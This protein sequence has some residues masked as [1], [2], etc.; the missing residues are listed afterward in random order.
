[1]TC[2]ERPYVPYII[3]CKAEDAWGSRTNEAPPQRSANSLTFMAHC[4]CP[5]AHHSSPAIQE[6]HKKTHSK[7]TQFSKVACMWRSQPACTFMVMGKSTEHKYILQGVIG[8]EG[9]VNNVSLIFNN[10]VHIFCI[11]SFGQQSYNFLLFWL[12]GASLLFYLWL[13]YEL[14]QHSCELWMHLMFSGQ[15]E[16]KKKKKHVALRFS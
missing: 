7:K 2:C 9:K 12:S 13:H 5:T 15:F 16:K 10:T 14:K 1:M 6:T 11:R 3:Y 4:I 8:E